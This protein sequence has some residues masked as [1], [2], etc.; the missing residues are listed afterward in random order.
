MP[1]CASPQ[2]HTRTKSPRRRRTSSGPIR[3]GHAPGTPSYVKLRAAALP[4]YRARK[5]RPP[6]HLARWLAEQDLPRDL[7][8]TELRVIGVVLAPREVGAPGLV[9]SVGEIATRVRRCRK[10]VQNALEA[11]GEHRR[12]CEGECQRPGFERKRPA[13]RAPR[14]RCYGCADPCPPGC[15]EHLELARRVPQYLDEEW[16]DEA[17]GRVWK[18]RQC[19]NTLVPG[20]AAQRAERAQRPCRSNRTH[21]IPKRGRA[22]F[23]ER[24]PLRSQPAAQD[25]P[26][27]DAIRTAAVPLGAVIADVLAL[28]AGGGVAS[29]DRSIDDAGASGVRPGEKSRD[30]GAADVRAA[31]RAGDPGV[32]RAIADAWRSWEAAR[33]PIETGPPPDPPADPRSPGAADDVSRG[34]G[35]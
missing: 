22:Y 5:L 1:D 15:A 13:D 18:R 3:P 4:W 17:T 2:P 9:A 29:G 31:D 6:P 26:L 23:S 24:T 11:L 20:T 27:R 32:D 34:G 10:S 28:R 8:E 19:R 35:A 25:A 16:R 14:P 7:N 21:C 12:P 33:A 30:A